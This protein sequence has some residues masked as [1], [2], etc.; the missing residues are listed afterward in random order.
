MY[1]SEEAT[2]QS[3]QDLAHHLTPNNA[4]WPLLICLLGPLRVLQAGRPMAVRGGGKIEAL[5]RLLALQHGYRVPRDRLLETLWP[6]T[7][8][9][10][11]GQSLN[12]LVYSLHKLLGES[13]G[14]ITPVLYEE[15]SYRL[16]VEAGIGVDV[17]CF[18]ALAAS[19]DR[20]H[21]AGNH[22]GA[23]AAYSRAVQLYRG[24][25]CAGGDMHGVVERERLH[26]RYLTLIARLAAYHFGEADYNGCLEHALRVLANDPC[27]ED[28]H[29]L[30]MRCY[31][32]R[33]ERA[34]AL[35]QY[36]L[37]ETLLRAEFSAVPEPATTILFDQIRLDP[38]SV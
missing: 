23:A 32:R 26:A 9:T 22:K 15:C 30:V 29:R 17:A 14:G 6:D 18:D 8:P 4:D 12:S 20:Q 16:N 21:R 31:V 33:G 27:R 19:G 35:R 34:Q 38:S 2:R 11:A 1:A 24:E 7:E 5:L 36:R 3:S 28:A 37:C 25:L 13:I 10:M